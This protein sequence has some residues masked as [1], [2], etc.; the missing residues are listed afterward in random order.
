M[1]LHLKGSSGD[2]FGQMTALTELRKAVAPNVHEQN[3]LHGKTTI[4]ALIGFG[5]L[6]VVSSFSIIH[7]YTLVDRK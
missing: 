7:L 4:Q 1:L 2:P 5:Y 6:W 3:W